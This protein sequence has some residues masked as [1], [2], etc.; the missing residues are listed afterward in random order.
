M[1]V[2]SAVNFSRRWGNHKSDLRKGIHCSTALQRAWNKYG[3]TGLKF[4]KLL[5]CEPCNLLMYEQIFLDLLKPVFNTAKIAG[6]TLGVRP[7]PETL[8][9]SSAAAKKAWANLSLADRAKHILARKFSPEV[10]AKMSADRTGKKQ[11]PESIAKRSAAMMGHTCSAETIAKMSN[12][13][14]GK[15]FS[16]EHKANLSAAAKGSKKSPRT[17]EH[18]EKISAALKGRAHSEE[19]R[20]KNSAAQK[21]A[22]AKRKANATADNQVLEFD[23]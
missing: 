22:W 14:K 15:T 13:K 23:T 10:R 18:L 7:S 19:R 1:Y 2:G 16:E 20:A 11:S 5:L 3:E 4:E 6:N 21:L 8:L 9:K 12:T 17:A